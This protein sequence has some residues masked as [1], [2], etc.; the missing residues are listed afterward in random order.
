[1]PL[2][3]PLFNALA[4]VA[5]AMTLLG[6]SASAESRN[7]SD[8]P[9]RIHIFRRSETTFYQHRV[10]DEARGDGRANL[11]EG[12][13]P[14]GIDFAFDCSEKLQTSSGFETFPARWKKPNEELIVLQPEFGKAGSYS[15]C[16]LKVQIKDFAYFSRNGNL[17]TEPAADFK[18][19]M[20]EHAYDPEH[21]QNTPTPSKPASTPA[22]AAPAPTAPSTSEP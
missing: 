3:R 16:K 15:T 20:T 14:K 11:F 7:I 22:P 12:G 6:P 2:T 17:N 21:G 4:A 18:H 13:Q 10:P 8:Y 1:M 5:T 9:L 19:W